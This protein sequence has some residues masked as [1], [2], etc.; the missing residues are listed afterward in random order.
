VGVL[1]I[2]RYP[3]K[4]MLGELLE[5]V[6][7]GSGGCEGDRRWVVTDADTGERIANKRGPTDPGL[8][9]C[10]A[11]LLDEPGSAPP[12][13]VTLPDGTEVVGTAIETAL[14]DLLGRR[15]VLREFEGDGA[16]RLGAPAAHHDFA[17]LHVL[18]TRT[19]AHLR[20]VAPASDWDARRFRPNLVLDDG[21]E[22]GA[23]SEDALL[24]RSL[25][26]PSGCELR[27]GLPTPRCVV[28]TRAQDDMPRDR[29]ILRTIARYHL[30][31]VG[32]YGRYACAGAYA[33]VL[34]PGRVGVGEWLTPSAEGA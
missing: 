3:V 20:S 16:G 32:S 21:D 18:T 4:A 30:I 19:L 15:V 17:P 6:E 23:F 34:E 26:A 29:A 31:D 11:Q 12:L 5:A 2:W 10:R 13:K 28:P 7:V 14:S 22:P 33:E 27:V 9:A 25:R 24:G 8:R 1:A